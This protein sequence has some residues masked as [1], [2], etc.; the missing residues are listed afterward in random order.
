[1][2][3]HKRKGFFEKPRRMQNFHAE[4]G[5]EFALTDRLRTALELVSGDAALSHLLRADAHSITLEHVQL[6]SSLLR[7]CQE[8]APHVWVRRPAATVDSPRDAQTTP[9]LGRRCT[10]CFRAR[11]RSCHRGPQSV[12]HTQTWRRDWSGSATRRPTASTRPCWAMCP[13]PA[14]PRKRRKPW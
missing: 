1:M 11:R 9:I 5:M 14:A 4:L 10:S 6:L 13:A 7:K 2:T 12:S 8:P 3:T